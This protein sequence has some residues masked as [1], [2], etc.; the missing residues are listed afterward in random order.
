MA[1]V[2][3][4]I[5]GLAGAA[6]IGVITKAIDSSHQL[7]R[8][9]WM[10]FGFCLAYLICKSYSE[11]SLL[12]LTQAAIVHLR[13]RLS[14]K[15]LRTPLEKLQE[16]GKHSLLVILTKDID[17]L[18]DAFQL[19]PVAFGNGIL[20][21]ALL[22]YMAS[23]SWRMFLMLTLILLVCMFVYHFVERRPL[24][25][26]FKVREQLDILYGDFRNLI[27]GIKELQL[28]SQRGTVFIEQV[29]APAAQNF[30]RF[31]IRS[32][33]GYTWI[34]NIGTILFYLIVGMMLFVVPLWLPERPGTLTTV[35]LILLYLMRP[36]GEMMSVFPALRQAAIALTKIQQLDDVL[37][38]T[39]P[40]SLIADPF[41]TGAPLF[42]E[43]QGVSHHYP[44]TDS[45]NQF[46]LG[47]VDLTVRRGEILF[48]TGGN[49][50]GKTTLAMLLL[51]LYKPQ[52]GTIV[53]NG[54]RVTDANVERYREDFSAVFSDFHLFEHLLGSREGA[55]NSSAAHYLEAFDIRQKVKIVDGKFSTIDLSSGQR[56][57]LALV[58]SYLEDR[59]IYVL[60][61][62][63]ADQD[64]VFKRVFYTKI[65]QDLKARGKTVLVITHDDTYF[66]RADRIVKL[67]DGCLQPMS[68][69]AHVA[70]TRNA[71]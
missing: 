2:T 58:S 51:G 31:F 15:L 24:Q 21:L 20:I 54:T 37:T 29:I 61:E 48:I 46:N 63:A 39:E 67:L 19:V 42:L 33:S 5:S 71:V 49:G 4:F 3:G 18:I 55:L 12:H 14:R 44:T 34:L 25:Q 10:F 50:S 68:L 6:V 53:L 22:T 45:D 36:V 28:N 1:T 26:L 60:D 17:R 30:M 13:V 8:L 70:P 52:A 56:R 66:S 57:R 7:S 59:P 32:M 16:L 65:L 38:I 23:L 64:P 11:I 27:E 62:W 35:T 40:T 41:S 43:L 9:P 69:Q 47:P